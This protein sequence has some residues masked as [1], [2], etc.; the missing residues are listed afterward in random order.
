MVAT[1]TRDISEAINAHRH[2]TDLSPNFAYAHAM[3]GAS[4]ALGGRP[5][6]G[7]EST[8]RAVRLSPRD[9]FSDDF[10][11][12]YA[13][14]HFQAGRYVEAASFAETAIQL[15]PEHP[16][17]HVIA[18]A[19]YAL[20]GN[21]KKAVDALARLKALVPEITASNVE[22]TFPYALAEDRARVSQGL[23]NAGLPN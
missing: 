16:T 20:A 3:L 21:D 6:E 12:F 8:S 7:I 4:L 1:A 15:R 18:T 5:E 23:R 10:Q 13:F 22:K 14:A 11:L 17:P 9:T 2:A 19:S